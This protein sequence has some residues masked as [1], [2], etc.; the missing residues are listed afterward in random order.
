M[1]VGM[2]KLGPGNNAVRHRK[3]IGRNACQG[4]CALDSYQAPTNSASSIISTRELTF[5]C[6]V[7]DWAW[8]ASEDARNQPEERCRVTNAAE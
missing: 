1:R 2:R 4:R 7:T 6:H 5:S 8:Q 3:S